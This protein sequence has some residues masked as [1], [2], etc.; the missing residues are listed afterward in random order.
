M[1]NEINSR[2][3]NTTSNLDTDSNSFEFGSKSLDIH[4]LL[5]IASYWILETAQLDVLK[6]YVNS[7]CLDTLTFAWFVAVHQLRI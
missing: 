7:S 2:V 3:T 6:L 1:D 5:L 4:L